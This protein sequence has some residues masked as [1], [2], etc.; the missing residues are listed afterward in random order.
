MTYNAASRAT[1]QVR[2]AMGM[3]TDALDVPGNETSSLNTRG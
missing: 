2:S 3:P 1:N